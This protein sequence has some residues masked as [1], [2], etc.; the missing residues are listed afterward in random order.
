MMRRLLHAA[1]ALLLTLFVLISC[2]DGAGVHPG[3]IVAE[4]KLQSDPAQ[5]DAALLC[6]PFAHPDKP[7]VLLVHGTFT[8]GF[9]QS[10]WSYLPLLAA[11]G[12]D[13]CT[14][15]YPDRGLGDMQLSAE[16]VAHALRRIHDQSGRAVALIGH[17]QGVAVARWAVKWWPSARAAVD[18]FVMLAGPNHGTER[19][20]NGGLLPL[21]SAV[22]LVPEVI[23]QFAPRSQF[24]QATN[25][26][27]E[28][29]GEISY[30]V[31]Y[32]ELD[33]LV[34]PVRPVPTAAVDYGLDNPRVA[35]ILLQDVCPGRFVDHVTIGLS[36]R[37]AFELVLDALSHD[38]PADVVRAGGAELCGL[39]ALVPEQIV[40]P[41]AVQDV[42]SV[43]QQEPVNGLPEPHFAT[44]EPPLQDYA[45][46]AE[47]ARHQGGGRSIE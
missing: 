39:A 6:A 15:S 40:A 41:D 7:P 37:L 21:L 3:E 26:G 27:D 18:D 31:L 32:T 44:E 1:A 47:Q 9:E 24:M 30:T 43:L 8:A 38:G 25:A 42:V 36:D 13:V 45:Q 14:V 19:A 22:G 12:Y 23:Y 5:L 29:P 17:S 34:Q 46:T 4:P 2:G 28:T 10:D 35:N 20:Q 16:Y 33:E 11:R